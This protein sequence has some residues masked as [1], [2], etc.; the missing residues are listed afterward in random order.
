[1]SIVIYRKV[2]VTNRLSTA[3]GTDLIVKLLTCVRDYLHCIRI[4]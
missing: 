4:A 3:H 1:M 2:P